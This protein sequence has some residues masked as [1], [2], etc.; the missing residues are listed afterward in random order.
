MLD[1]SFVLRNRKD[2]PKKNGL[3]GQESPGVKSAE[4]LH[5]WGKGNSGIGR[6]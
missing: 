6:L 3:S 2:N 5:N 4:L 1:K